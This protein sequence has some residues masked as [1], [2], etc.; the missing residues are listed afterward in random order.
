MNPSFF[1]DS[2]ESGV[3]VERD[4]RIVVHRGWRRRYPL[5]RASVKHFCR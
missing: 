1:Q 4:D 2:G 5:L 3:F